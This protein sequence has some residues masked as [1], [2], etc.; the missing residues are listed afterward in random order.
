[1]ATEFAAGVNFSPAAPCA[2]V[3]KAPFA[4]AVVPSFRNSV[5]PVT[6]VIL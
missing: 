2:A 5:P 1:L 6:L 4:T 3:M